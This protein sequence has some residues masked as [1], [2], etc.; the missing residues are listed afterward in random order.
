MRDECVNLPKPEYRL[1]QL[2][3]DGEDVFVTSIIDRYQARL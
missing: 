3:D 2:A 1:S